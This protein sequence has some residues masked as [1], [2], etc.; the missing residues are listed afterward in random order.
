[1]EVD[2]EI[3]PEERRERQAFGKLFSRSPF[4]REKRPALTCEDLMQQSEEILNSSFMSGGSSSASDAQ[5][6][7]LLRAAPDAASNDEDVPASEAPAPLPT[8]SAEVGDE[9]DGAYRV[10]GPM[11]DQL[12]RGAEFLRKKTNDGIQG[13][14]AAI[15]GTV[16]HAQ[17]QALVDRKTLLAAGAGNFALGLALLMALVKNFQLQRRVERRNHVLHMLFSQLYESQLSHKVMPVRQSNFSL[18]SV[19]YIYA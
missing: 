19:W 16:E 13:V 5:P 12:E 3:L 7:S 8:S 18:E 9:A 4:F 10:F 11:R 2:W 14:R 17:G 6:S 15:G 1:M